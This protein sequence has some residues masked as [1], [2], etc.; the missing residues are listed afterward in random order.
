MPDQNRC[1]IRLEIRLSHD[2][3][4]KL[5][6]YESKSCVPVQPLAAGKLSKGSIADV[7]KATSPVSAVLTGT[8]QE[9]GITFTV[10]QTIGTPYDGCG[11][12][13]MTITDFAQGQV[14]VQ[15]QSESAPQ[16]PCP[17]G[18][19]LLRKA[20]GKAC[21]KERQDRN[22]SFSGSSG[23]LPRNQ[24]PLPPLACAQGLSRVLRRRCRRL[25]QALGV[26]LLG[27]RGSPGSE[28]A[29]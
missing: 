29:V 6:G 13:S 21:R 1:N 27:T 22:H 9:G 17:A 8:A 11:I 23:G 7:I 3:P 15:W 20:R 12:T 5:M 2:L 14:R 18:K 19:M 28:S 16:P 24:P 25:S 26:P 10:E 4:R